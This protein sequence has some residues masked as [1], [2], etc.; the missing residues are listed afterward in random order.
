MTRHDVAVIM[1]RGLSRRMGQD[2]GLV[3]L[4]RNGP[5]LVRMIAD[6]YR[7]LGL[8]VLVVTL[9]DLAAAYRA[10]V[11]GDPRTVILTGE[12]GGDTARTMV[13]ARRALAGDSVTHLWAHPVDLPLVKG[14]TLAG[15]RD[16][17]RLRPAEAVRPVWEERP[18]H[19]VILPVD[20][21]EDFEG[22]AR[23]RDD[24]V[25]ELLAEAG[26]GSTFLVPVTD[27]GV[28]RDFDRPGDLPPGS[29]SAPD[30]V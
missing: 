6:T 5:P 26:T 22:L 8:P 11:G 29:P 21:V 14:A 3:R 27:P 13:L 10:A 4:T 15:L 30:E 9:P 28:S 25:R 1:A 23:W 16:V 7:A 24:P 19:P 18:G 2:K 20:L 12:T 17:S